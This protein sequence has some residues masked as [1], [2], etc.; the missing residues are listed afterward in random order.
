MDFNFSNK[1]SRFSHELGEEECTVS[2]KN[3]GSH[4]VLLVPVRGPLCCL[5]G[6]TTGGL[7]EHLLEEA[8]KQKS[9]LIVAEEMSI[10]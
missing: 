9:L 4:L 6:S 2:I 8:A 3:V 7:H 10:T 5:H 1:E